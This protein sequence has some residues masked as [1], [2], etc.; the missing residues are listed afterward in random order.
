MGS[1]S[2]RSDSRQERREVS[3]TGYTYI[4]QFGENGEDELVLLCIEI[5]IAR[6]RRL[7]SLSLDRNNYVNNTRNISISHSLSV[8][9]SIIAWNAKQTNISVI[10]FTN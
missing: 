9:L 7:V 10:L 5:N 2:N 8:L 4:R 3:E 1:R 6:K